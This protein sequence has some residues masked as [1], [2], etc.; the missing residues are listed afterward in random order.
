MPKNNTYTYWKKSM[1]LKM[2]LTFL[3]YCDGTFNK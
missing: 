3:V 2:N 1:L